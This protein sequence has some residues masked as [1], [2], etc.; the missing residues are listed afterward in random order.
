MQNLALLIAI[1]I[2]VLL[3]LLLR[4]HGA[5]VFLSLCAGS[6]LVLYYGND[7]SIVGNVIGN[8][9]FAV[10]QYSQ[11]TLLLLPAT[12]SLVILKG[13]M[14]GGK[15]LFNLIPAIAVGLVAALLAVPLLPYGAHNAITSTSGWKLLEHN[16][17]LV[18]GASVLASLVVLWFSHY[19]HPGHHRKHGKH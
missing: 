15:M 13:S 9:S 16:Q 6:L 19:K 14:A 10:S 4:S 17:Q 18:V 7:A 1:G 2:P 5:I 8:N 12:L 3:I 11:L